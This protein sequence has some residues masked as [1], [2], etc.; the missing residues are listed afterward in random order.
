MLQAGWLVLRAAT[1]SNRNPPVIRDRQYQG[2][3]RIYRQSMV[4]TEMVDW[5]LEIGGSTVLSRHLASAMWQVL[6]EE[7]VISQG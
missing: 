2:G 4:G 1:A 3:H 7:G 5:L 6:L